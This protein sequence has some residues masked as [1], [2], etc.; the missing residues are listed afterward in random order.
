M[1]HRRASLE[2]W[3]RLWSRPAP[4]GAQQVL[5]TKRVHRRTTPVQPRP[6]LPGQSFHFWL[7]SLMDAFRP[8]TS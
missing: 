4:L 5:A 2:P 8:F 6:A 3:A 7:L 1:E